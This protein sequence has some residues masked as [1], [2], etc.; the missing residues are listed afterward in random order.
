MRFAYILALLAIAGG[1]GGDPA[2]SAQQQ[3]AEDA[4]APLRFLLG[5]WEARSIG[6]PGRGTGRREYRLVLNDHFIAVRNVATYPPQQANPKGE[7]HE[8][9]GYISYDRGRKRYMFRQFHG[10]G[11]VNTYVSESVAPDAVVFTTEAI[12]NIPPG[13][14]GRETYRVTGADERREL[15]ELAEPGKD[16][17]TYSETQLTRRR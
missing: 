6:R 2:L 8:D 5:N 12:E 3:K 10:E 11:F 14:R 13:W 4:W 9:V 7:T 17:S 15:F 16:F 1:S